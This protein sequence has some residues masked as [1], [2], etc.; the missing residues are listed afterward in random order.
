MSSAGSRPCGGEDTGLT[1]G[2]LLW[3]GIGVSATPGNALVWESGGG[4]SRARHSSFLTRRKERLAIPGYATERNVQ[5]AIN[6]LTVYVEITRCLSRSLAV[7]SSRSCSRFLQ[8]F[9]LH[10]PNIT[11]SSPP[12]HW[13]RNQHSLS[14]HQHDSE[15]SA[16][17]LELGLP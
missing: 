3:L 6:F 16:E 4:G 17:S 7:A 12:P 5:K 1:S 9:T 2:D 15:T 13:N 10:C 8:M 14:L 11:E